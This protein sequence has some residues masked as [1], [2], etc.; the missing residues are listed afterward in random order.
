MIPLLVF[1]TAT[2]VGDCCCYILDVH[3]VL[4]LFLLFY[5]SLLLLTRCTPN[6]YSTWTSCIVDVFSAVE[7]VIVN[8]VKSGTSNI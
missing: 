4:L 6:T 1:V 5:A 3:E 2:V 8:A 7:T